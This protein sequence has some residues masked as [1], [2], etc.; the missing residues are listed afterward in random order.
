M[1]NAIPFIGWIL[2]F[3]FSASLA[4]P[5]Y[6]I[7]TVCGIGETYFYFLPEVYRHIGFWSCIG[8]FMVI[9]ILKVVLIPKIANI[10]STSE[11]K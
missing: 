4:I 2:S 1:L 10:S 8:L 7:W 3:V 5:F 11:A 9:S 6:F